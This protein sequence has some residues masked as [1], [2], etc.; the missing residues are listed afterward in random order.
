MTLTILAEGDGEHWELSAP[1]MLR[2]PCLPKDAVTAA[3]Q[4][5]AVLGKDKGLRGIWRAGA[6][7]RL[8][9]QGS[10]YCPGLSCCPGPPFLTLWFCPVRRWQIKGTVLP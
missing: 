3:E 10:P 2:G 7:N 8:E 1:V 4:I 9:W 5:R 6:E